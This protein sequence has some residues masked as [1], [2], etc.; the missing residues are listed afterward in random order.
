MTL[1]YTLFFEH[2]TVAQGIS[3]TSCR[4]AVWGNKRKFNK[5]ML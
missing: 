1:A 4:A 3:I 2:V 5:L